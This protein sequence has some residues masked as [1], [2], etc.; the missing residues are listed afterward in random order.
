MRQLRA[1][2]TLSECGNF[3]LA[4]K[5]MHVTQAGLSAMIRELESQLDSQLF[6]R[7]TRKVEITTAGNAFL[8]YAAE[9][10]QRLN[11][12]IQRVT[13]EKGRQCLCIGLTPL[14]AATILPAISDR[15][16]Q[17]CPNV[18]LDVI[19][20]DREQLQRMVES[21][22]L[23]VAYGLFFEQKSVL[24]QALVFSAGLILIAPASCVQLNSSAE[25]S[26]ERNRNLACQLPLLTLRR[27]SHFERFVQ[28][29]LQEIDYPKVVRHD[30]QHLATLISM[31]DA[32]RGWAL[33]PSFAQLACKRY[34]NVRIMSVGKT[35]PRLDFFCI[36]RRG[37]SI[38]AALHSLSEIVANE[39]TTVR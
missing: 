2:V 34:K 4:A 25:A 27:G 10:L 11:D 23:D 32:G 21:E 13:S 36:T 3:T 20:A 17:A 16:K 15:F 1:F 24:T 29:F 26:Y 38:P 37:T 9:A 39:C 8:P 7:T 5:H 14:V 31:V 35:S 6:L 33:I 30:F 19:D 12:G 18:E 28:A 22:Q